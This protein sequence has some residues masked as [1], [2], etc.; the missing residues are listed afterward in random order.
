MFEVPEVRRKV[1]CT[2]NLFQLGHLQCKIR[3][4]IFIKLYFRK[5]SNLYWPKT[6]LI[7]IETI[8]LTGQFVKK[9]AYV[10]EEVFS[11]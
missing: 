6:T 3:I 1:Q 10:I 9:F 7:I 2:F 5:R 11:P 8:D 4:C